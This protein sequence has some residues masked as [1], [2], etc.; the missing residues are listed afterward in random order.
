MKF[1]HFMTK[2]TDKLNKVKK[3]CGYNSIDDM[4]LI[5]FIIIFSSRFHG[6]TTFNSDQIMSG[7]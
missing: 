2:Q 3:K 5:I 4:H 6:F 1:Y 7:V